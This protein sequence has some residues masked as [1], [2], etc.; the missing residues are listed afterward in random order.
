MF[1]VGQVIFKNVFH[2][3]NVGLGQSLNEFSFKHTL[4]PT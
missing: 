3:E 2:T 4:K 1:I